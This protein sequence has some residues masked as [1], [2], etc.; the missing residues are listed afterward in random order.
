MQSQTLRFFFFFLLIGILQAL[1][2]T[3][4]IVKWRK[5]VRLRSWS[6][7]WYHV[8]IALAVLFFMLSAYATWQRQINGVP[9][10]WGSTMSVLLSLWY[11]PKLP[12]SLVMAITDIGKALWMCSNAI[13]KKFTRK[14]LSLRVIPE[15][16]HHG[17]QYGADAE[18]VISASASRRHF[19]QTTGWALAGTPFVLMS[20]GM[21][22]SLYDFQVYRVDV[23]IKNL[24]RQFEGMTIAQ[25]SDVHAGS[26]LS[27]APVEEIVRITN[28]LKSDMIVISGDWV[29]ARTEEIPRIAP[30]IPKLTAPLG[31]WGSLGNHDHYMSDA[32]HQRLITW[33]RSTG[34]NLLIN[35]STIFDVDGG[36]L[37]LAI[38][39]NIGLRQ[40]FGNLP[41]AMA[42]IRED[43]PT[44]L[45]SH[46]P[47]FWDIG[48]REKTRIDLMLSGHT[49][50]GQF[51]AEFGTTQFGIAQ[52]VYKQWA[53][54]YSDG[55]QH[56]YV[57]RGVG[58][59][60]VPARIGI[61]PEITCLTL[62]RG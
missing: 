42:K 19:L 35:Q 25:I 56:L 20:Y 49:H 52:L 31:V 10:V 9:N 2:D 29:N 12:I 62:R 61:A 34:T 32:D 8:P 47:T 26:F 4:I 28:A 43:A 38:T 21:A 48:V 44:I 17:Q 36:H 50:G 51:G 18:D 58:T 16:I 15:E 23:P 46:D 30:Y 40:Y 37:N 53:G 55:T 1:I 45:V 33:I 22:K 27:S 13:R 6:V 3:Y 14:Q 24:P 59:T 39:D 7:Y 5:Y 54:L 60:G 41:M 57:N 11:L